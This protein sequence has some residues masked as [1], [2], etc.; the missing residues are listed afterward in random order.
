[1]KHGKVYG[2]GPVK[3]TWV[4]PRCVCVH[5]CAHVYQCREG[6][7]STAAIVRLL[8]GGS[9]WAETWRNPKSFPVKKSESEGLPRRGLPFTKPTIP[10]RW[11]QTMKTTI[12]RERVAG[13]GGWGA[14]MWVWSLGNT[15]VLETEVWQ[16]CVHQRSVEE[17]DLRVHSRTLQYIA[18]YWMSR[19]D[20][21]IIHKIRKQ[22]Y[23]TQLR[24]GY[25]LGTGTVPRTAV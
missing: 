15:P 3:D 16:L 19:E 6:G 10:G 25:C 7:E 23:N 1:M 5:V 9:G 21:S 11:Q 2:R 4:E 13:G 20:W 17:H 8:I 18:M 22:W 24:G 12:V 14:D